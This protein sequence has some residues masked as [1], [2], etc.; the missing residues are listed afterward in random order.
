[1]EF[2]QILN[3]SVVVITALYVFFLFAISR[4]SNKSAHILGVYMLVLFLMNLIYWIHQNSLISSNISIVIIYPLY[5]LQAPLFYL[6]IKSLTDESFYL[7]KKLF[8]HLFPALLMVLFTVTTFLLLIFEISDAFLLFKK[9][10]FS[11]TIIINCMQ[12]ITYAILILLTLKKFVISIRN[13]FS[14]IQ[15]I[16]LKWLKLCIWLYIIYVPSDLMMIF[17]VDYIVHA[18]VGLII[19]YIVFIFLLG[20]F[21]LKQ[22]EIYSVFSEDRKIQSQTDIP[23]TDDMTMVSVET[24]LSEESAL[25]KELKEILFQRLDYL[26]TNEKIFLNI[27]LN[28]HD[29]AKLLNT[30]RTYLSIVIHEKFNSNFY[31]L[32]NSYRVEEAKKYLAAPEYDKYNLDG[33]AEMSGFASRNA[34]GRTFKSLTGETPTEFKNKMRNS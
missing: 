26:L 1:M 31:N 18:R 22:N 20:F 2:L 21:G 16:R 14:D 8:N 27:S 29:L 10:G 19:Y 6:Y 4:S 25:S 3:N 32:I 12:F 28:S 7:H 30:N 13:N 33:I 5:L 17:I 11:V 24:V 15:H 34:F 23:K 9:W